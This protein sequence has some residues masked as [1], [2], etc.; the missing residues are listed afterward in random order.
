[1]AMSTGRRSPLTERQ[2]LYAAVLVLAFRVFL[3]DLRVALGGHL[4][5]WVTAVV[6]IGLV[7]MLLA[8]WGRGE[9]VRLVRHR[10]DPSAPVVRPAPET[11]DA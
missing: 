6:E 11:V 9:H 7:V 10:A 1:M 2:A 4:G 8:T 5:S 3:G